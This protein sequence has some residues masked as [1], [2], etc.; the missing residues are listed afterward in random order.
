MENIDLIYRK[1]DAFSELERGNDLLEPRLKKKIRITVLGLH[2]G[3]LAILV[4]WYLITNFL[5]AKK[6]TVIKVTLVSPDTGSAAI[7]PSPPIFTPAPPAVKPKHRPKTSPT[8]PKPKPKV[9]VKP[10]PKW[11]P[12]T[13][14]DINISKTVIKNDPIPAPARPMLSAKDI[15]KNL[16]N[17]YRNSRVKTTTTRRTTQGG[18][19][20]SQ[21][22]FEK[23]S[24]L[25]Y[26]SWQ[27]PGQSELHGRYP[28]V[29]VEITVDASGR[30]VKSRIA[31]KSGIAVMDQSAQKLLRELRT[32]PRPPSGKTTFTVSLEI[33]RE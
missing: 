30:V 26:Q 17:S 6:P 22:Y 25:I 13:A 23:I 33:V 32:L 8:P 4:L 18:T 3:F 2:F 14:N 1:K 11:K 5:I 21:N 12:R 7:L 28:V 29:D 24:A 20:I 27:Q 16:R 31:R 10:K 15:E 19:K 9:K